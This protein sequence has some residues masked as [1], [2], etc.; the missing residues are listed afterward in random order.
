MTKSR[1]IDLVNELKLLH[2]YFTA[3]NHNFD[4]IRPE[5][6]EDLKCKFS[7]FATKLLKGFRRNVRDLSEKDNEKID[8]IRKECE[9][10]IKEIRAEY[11]EEIEA[12]K[13]ALNA[14]NKSI[15][16][17]SSCVQEVSS[18]EFEIT[19]VVQSYERRLQEQI[20]LAKL[21]IITDLGKQIQRLASGN[22]D[23]EEWPNE[24]LALREKL[25]QPYEKNIEKIKA[26]HETEINYLKE[27]LSRQKSFN[28]R[29]LS[30]E[31]D[32]ADG[33]LLDERNSYKK[34]AEL[35]RKILGEL[36]KYFTQ[37]E[38]EVNNTIVDTLV[39]QGMEKNLTDIERELNDS[40]SSSKSELTNS[41]GKRVHI[42]PNIKELLTIIENSAEKPT[43]LSDF[44]NELDIC[45]DNLKA[46]ANEILELSVNF[47]Q[48]N[49]D[50][51][52]RDT[53]INS[54]TRRLIDEVRMKQE[55]KDQAIEMRNVIDTLENERLVL[56]RQVTELVEKSNVT[57][58][59][60]EKA[61]VK[62][63][64][65]VEDG[66]REIVS[67]G[68]GGESTVLGS[69]SEGDQAIATFNEL[70]ERV[71]WTISKA[72][73]S[74]QELFHLL[75]DLV[76]IGEKIIDEWKMEKQDLEQ[77]VEV[78]DKKYRQTCRFL[79]EQ[80]QD[81]ELERDESQRQIEQLQSQLR[82]NKR[83]RDQFAAISE[84]VDHLENQLKEAV[85]NLN[86]R[87]TK[88][89]EIETE[90]N[91]AVEKIFFLR[92]VIRDLETQI[93]Q[94][95]ETELGLRTLIS[96]LECMIPV[97]Q[98]PLDS[99]SRNVNASDAQ[100]VREHI[101]KLES[102]VQRLRLGQ[103]L[104]GSEGPLKE[105]KLQLIDIENIL[106]KRTK[107]LEDI[108]TAVSSTACSSPSEDMS[109]REVVRP[110]TPNSTNTECEVPLQQL[111]RLKEKL[112]RHSRV[113]DAAMKRIR[114][115]E[116]Q[117]FAQK[118]S[119][120]EHQTEKEILKKEI[121]DQLVLISSLQIRLDEQRIRAEHIEKQTNTSLEF[122]IY[123][124]QK[125]VTELQ[126]RLQ[127]RNK[128]INQL[129]AI[130]KETKSKLEEKQS[131][132]DD[133]IIISLQKEIDHLRNQNELLRKRLNNGV[134]IIPNLVENIISDKNSDI[135]SLRKQLSQA[136]KKLELYDSLG[137]D[138][139][140]ISAIRNIK[141]CGSTLV[142]V[143]SFLEMSSPDKPRRNIETSASLPD[144]FHHRPLKND[145]T[146]LGSLNEIKEIS[147]IDRMS[148]L[149]S[150]TPLVSKSEK[151]VHFETN[152]ADISNVKEKDEIIK[153]LNK[154]L[155]TLKGIESN[156]DTIQKQLEE[157]QD[158]LK[159]TTEKFENELKE[160]DEKERNFK[161][162]LM[163][164][165]LHLEQ[166]QQEIDSLKED[167]LRKDNM[168]ME[169]MKEQK[170]LKKLLD[171]HENQLRQ[172]LEIEV[173]LNTK[174]KMIIELE[175]Q[176]SKLRDDEAHKEKQLSLLEEKEEET[177]SLKLK[178]DILTKENDHKNDV[179]NN[180]ETENEKLKNEVVEE[181]DNADKLYK[182]LQN[183]KTKIEE[184]N[185]QII[186]LEESQNN[187]QKETHS[188]N[189]LK[190]QIKNLVKEKEEM[191]KTIINQK[192]IINKFNSEN[193]N[194]SESISQLEKELNQLRKHIKDLG[195]EIISKNEELISLK[196]Y[197][198]N[199][200]K[201]M[202][203]F[204]E[205]LVEKEK[206]IRQ[207]KDDSNRLQSSLKT[208]QNKMQETGNVVDLATRL[209]EEQIKNG[210]LT[211][212]LALLKAKMFGR[213]PMVE[214]IEVDE[215]TG[216]VQE[217][218]D[219]SAKLDS[220]ILEAVQEESEKEDDRME[221]LEAE[222]R[223]LRSELERKTYE[224][225]QCRLEDGNLIE[226]LRIELE[227]A[228]EN[229]KEAEEVIE[230][231]KSRYQILEI[232]CTKLRTKLQSYA[233]S[234]SE[235]TQYKELPPKE[236]PE[237]M[238]LRLE[239][240]TLREDIVKLRND[241]KSTKKSKK[242]ADANN[243][244][245]VDEL[246]LRKR[247]FDRL[248]AKLESNAKNEALL[249]DK[250][251]KYNQK[252]Q[253]KEAE[254]H[255]IQNFMSEIKNERDQLK[256]DVSLLKESLNQKN[257]QGD[258]P[259]ILPVEDQLLD[260]I[261]EISTIFRNDKR[262][263]EYI[264]KITNENKKLKTKVFQLESEGINTAPFE[265]P[266]N[267][268]NYL[269]AKCLRVESY[270][271]AL[272]FQKR[273]LIS[274][275]GS[276]GNVANVAD[277][278]VNRRRAQFSGVKKF[279]SAVYAVI[280]ILRMKYL[281]RR[282]HS[283]TRIAENVNARYERVEGSSNQR[284]VSSA[285]T[286]HLGQPVSSRQFESNA[287][288]VFRSNQRHSANLFENNAETAEMPMFSAS[289]PCREKSVFRQRS[290]SNI[291]LLRAPH[292][293]GQY[294]ERCNR[295]QENLGS[296]LNSIDN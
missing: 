260:K 239:T 149:K 175:E 182:E 123:D 95:T 23:D 98:S 83:D 20:S 116:M 224:L 261:Q 265:S 279:R 253:D 53:T 229:E 228:T 48:K 154:R 125:E 63:A 117:V 212:Q 133:E 13:R 4:Q 259:E 69:P 286:F 170:Q 97:D 86:A 93:K 28:A 202:E 160:K 25:R 178:L 192:S 197:S 205:L 219:Y 230:E 181:R 251:V 232:E 141:N 43:E 19:E 139:S 207:F 153:N 107:E 40:T 131:E 94:K 49:P 31:I 190:E 8:L 289:P 17:S 278:F 137:L 256:K 262:T 211:E 194:A 50:N 58:E 270:R 172:Y 168:Y 150:S 173:I 54:L 79:E 29:R 105:L 272:I 198:R 21:D 233:A 281:V 112:I 126:E 18:G 45:L 124:L 120:D 24:L 226:K 146:F 73:S 246:A 65:L 217:E 292:L 156:V 184:L 247:E 203:H 118:S 249:M 56:E 147:S 51:V 293:L 33:N 271:K 196:N 122:R 220:N 189:N 243:K 165:E 244:Y 64:Q 60:L 30:K 209:R 235:S 108:H 180:L 82:D 88:F 135:E 295:L 258:L 159:I 128:T 248:Q 176:I 96:D 71:R 222:C 99:P 104:V 27:Q 145:T 55:Y 264:I 38:D 288:N 59:E 37:C 206:I 109:I 241:L 291:N 199:L 143:A 84:E 61:R 276:Y 187:L 1:L 193:E 144:F 74:D 275:L 169:M 221:Q 200:E 274:L 90:K 227:A 14:S 15:L 245:L 177:E 5:E 115:L 166:K 85:K 111:A 254:I 67:E 242:E 214:S 158:L 89:K 263:M 188:I 167:G 171:D 113:E 151:R 208:I 162:D 119:I 255:R 44:R 132:V 215:I 164:K 185:A 78:A 277:G 62:I 191:E 72:P 68:F 218:L 140:Q 52:L 91:E 130:V 283:G 268:A 80:A 273:Y 285:R 3:R 257:Q 75:E 223:L 76:K 36:M 155:E 9:E 266:M 138:K 103:E 267:R 234:K 66:R 16:Q 26:E 213:D 34:Q 157:T 42:A 121:A 236:D 282:W 148:S 237:L 284:P 77:Q 114:D 81:R 129:E 225:S 183:K 136:E 7:D 134:D 210:E 57:Q 201:E 22:A 142:E 41:L 231:L 47:S 70:Q 12:L 110:K 195:L 290:N 100:K 6:F 238:R 280:I 240:Q 294:A 46:E 216:K 250:L 106:E 174:N 32:H 35:L 252:F 87:E 204:Q 296:I 163:E 152:D 287:A 179:I 39:R 10:K 92:E 269:F 127:Q 161:I 2:D 101:A 11:D 102:E 186:S